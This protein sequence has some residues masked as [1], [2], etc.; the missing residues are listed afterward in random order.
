[1][2]SSGGS[3]AALCSSLGEKYGHR[4]DTYA[5][6]HCCDCSLPA[7]HVVILIYPRNICIV[8]FIIFRPVSNISLRKRTFRQNAKGVDTG[9]PF[10]HFGQCLG[11]IRLLW[12]AWQELSFSSGGSGKEHFPGFLHE[13]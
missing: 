6:A 11:A 5:A 12:S 13:A 7:S 1:M 8:M 4:Y 2:T 9:R 10:G 3:I